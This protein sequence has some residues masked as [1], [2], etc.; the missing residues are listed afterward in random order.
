MPDAS[1][2][3]PK[4]VTPPPLPATPVPPPPSD[5]KKEEAPVRKGLSFPKFSMLSKKPGELLSRKRK[6]DPVD[7]SA[8]PAAPAPHQTIQKVVLDP[9]HKGG[10]RRQPAEKLPHPRELPPAPADIPSPKVPPIPASTP[11][12]ASTE[13]KAPTPP[14]ISPVPTP[15]P[16][17]PTAPVSST[18]TPPPAPAHVPAASTAPHKSPAPA[19]DKVPI[20]PPVK[21]TELPKKEVHRARPQWVKIVLAV[22]LRIVLL[23]AIVG[24]GIAA[25]YQLRE[26]RVEGFVN[27]PA[28]FQLKRVCVVRDF[29]ADVLNL[30]EELA[31]ERTPIHS[32]IEQQEEVVSRSKSDVAGREERI[33]LLKE[34]IGNAQKEVATALAEAN[35]SSN[36]IWAGQ[37]AA[38]DDEYTAKKEE[39]HQRIIARADQIKI[40]YVENSDVRDPEVWVNA[41]RLALYDAPK[42]INPTAEREWAE[43][44]LV[45]WKKFV[46]T[47][48]Q[49]V[50]DLKKQ[51]DDIQTS[52]KGRIAEINTRVEDLNQR[53]K[54]T[55]TEIEPI[56]SELRSAQAALDKFKADQLGLEAPFY[57]QVLEAPEGA[58]LQK[59]DFDP[60][61]NRFSWREINRD[62]QYQPAEG[63]VGNYYLWVSLLSADNQEYWSFVPFTIRPFRTTQIIIQPGAIVSVRNVLYSATPASPAK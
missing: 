58:I 56:R 49:R 39:I 19:L 5:V 20:A 16:V 42:G 15:A 14:P 55:E 31:T 4:P 51:V 50:A 30:A 44:Q 23:A 34:E 10:S 25:Y 32:D 26:T 2:Q 13:A 18:S 11:A 54:E 48:Q 59:I 7:P 12:A 43:S 52:P 8:A 57:K 40:K 62:G 29:R 60:Q 24:L 45:E 63:Q 46:T 36:K 6:G 37:G 9:S 53:V 38:L 61:T 41:F 1:G 22:F 47:Y 27:V 17:I 21:P 33:R 35:V 28:G 3:P